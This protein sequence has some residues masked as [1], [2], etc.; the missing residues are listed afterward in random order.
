MLLLALV[1]VLLAFVV[2]VLATSTLYRI[3]SSGMELTLHCPRP[4][5]GCEAKRADRVLVW[6]L[7]YDLRDP[8]WG[9]VVAFRAPPL[10]REK[11]GSEGVR[12]KRIVAVGGETWEERNGDVYI[13]GRRL[14]EPYVSPRLHDRGALYARRQIPSDNYFVMGDNRADS[15]DSR[16]WGTLRR[17]AIIVMT[18]WPLGRLSIR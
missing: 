10:A 1:G 7:L 4:E 6:R 14:S 18:Y 9:D 17:A 8:R 13:D 3:P 2:V 11:C 5:P 16:E 15:C 12:I